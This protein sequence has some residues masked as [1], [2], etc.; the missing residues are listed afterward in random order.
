MWGGGGGGPVTCPNEQ[1][2][3]SDYTS[4]LVG[5]RYRVILTVWTGSIIGFL[6]FYYQFSTLF[7]K[8]Q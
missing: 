2:W 6:S 3:F 5:W 4:Q 8:S 1:F 7:R